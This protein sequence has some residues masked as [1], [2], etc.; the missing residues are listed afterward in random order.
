VPEDAALGDPDRRVLTGVDQAG[1]RD[2]ERV[3]DPRQRGEVRVGA[4]LFQRHEDPFA[5]PGAR[6]EL[7]Q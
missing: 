4:A 3:A 2:A 1:D 5:D 7:V 6:G